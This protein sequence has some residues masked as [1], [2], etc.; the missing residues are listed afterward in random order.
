MAG[1]LLGY[2]LWL[3]LS[4]VWSFTTLPWQGLLYAASSLTTLVLPAPRTADTFQLQEA[5]RTVQRL[6]QRLL[7]REA[8]IKEGQMHLDEA[9]KAIEHLDGK[10]VE[11]QTNGSPGAGTKSTGVPVPGAAPSR[12]VMHLTFWVAGVLPAY[13]LLQQHHVPSINKKFAKT[14]LYPEAFFYCLEFL[15]AGLSPTPR[16][17]ATASTFLSGFVFSHWLCGF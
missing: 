11:A 14:V 6:R 7:R 1:K 16:I 17:I 8:T 5:E 13:W 4:S 2:S 10:L 3:S 9:R 15:G 12:L